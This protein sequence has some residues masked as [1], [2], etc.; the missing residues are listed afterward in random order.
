MGWFGS[1]I[2]RDDETKTFAVTATG[3][4]CVWKASRNFLWHATVDGLHAVCS[5]AIV[6]IEDDVYPSTADRSNDTMT[7]ERCQDLVTRRSCSP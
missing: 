4:S 7:C 5:R 6:L 1:S 2:P 3:E